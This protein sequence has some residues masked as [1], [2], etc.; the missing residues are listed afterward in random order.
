MGAGKGSALAVLSWGSPGE[1]GWELSHPA[2]C[3]LIQ[4]EIS[5]L[6]T[7]DV[8]PKPS[9]CAGQAALPSWSTA[10]DREGKLPW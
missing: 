10:K 4:P 1:P 2:T 8:H 3:S 9:P 6:L 7:M 5:Q